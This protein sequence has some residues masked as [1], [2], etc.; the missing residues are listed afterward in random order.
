MSSKKRKTDL[1]WL[2]TG[3]TALEV[4]E[5]TNLKVCHIFILAYKKMK[6]F[7]MQMCRFIYII[8]HLTNF[9]LHKN[10]V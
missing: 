2:K 7:R 1:L 6:R 9:K 5:K 10:L 4:E 8:H 3:L